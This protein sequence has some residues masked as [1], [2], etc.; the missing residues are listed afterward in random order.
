MLQPGG[1][2]RALHMLGG[3]WAVGSPLQLTGKMCVPHHLILNI[4]CGTY[5]PDGAPYA[6]KYDVRQVIRPDSQLFERFHHAYL[7]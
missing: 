2:K 1:Y 6:C 7:H 3:Q 5:L 4:F